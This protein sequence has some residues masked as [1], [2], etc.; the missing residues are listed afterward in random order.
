MLNAGEII[1]RIVSSLFLKARPAPS[2]TPSRTQCTGGGHG[3]F[4]ENDH[5]DQ[6]CLG[7]LDEMQSVRK[8]KEH[9][10]I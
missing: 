6:E 7:W 10:R 9:V 8:R 5:G 1:N 2:L 3:G 4:L